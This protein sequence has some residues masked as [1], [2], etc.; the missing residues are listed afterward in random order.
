MKKIPFFPTT[1][2]ERIC[3]NALRQ[4]GLL[5]L[6]PTPIRIDRFVEKH[7][8][9]QPTY[10]HLPAGL[11]GYTSF[12]PRGVEAIVVSQAF[13]DEGTAIAE[14]RLRTTLAHESGHGLFHTELFA[15]ETPPQSLF[16]GTP[17]PDRPSILCRSGD[18]TGSEMPPNH[19]PSRLEYQANKA[20][21]ALLL[22][23]SLVRS[24]LASLLVPRGALNKPTLL[25]ARRDEAIRLVAETFDVNPVVA[26]LRLGAVFPEAA[27]GQAV[28]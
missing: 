8:R 27:E 11:L 3:E 26:R 19:R 20:I 7:F 14:R 16:G 2:F 4:H 10:E 9:T 5:P 6:H 23:R 24:A 17:P 25:A 12:G 28:L 22:P 21:G 13:D 1:E 18:V 15:V